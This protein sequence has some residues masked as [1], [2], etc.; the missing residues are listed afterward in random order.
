MDIPSVT[1]PDTSPTAYAVFADRSAT[2]LGTLW[3][4][5]P[6]GGFAT[7]VFCLANS[8]AIR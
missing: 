6:I 1:V 8:P 5:L 3:S 2:C 4:S 7:I